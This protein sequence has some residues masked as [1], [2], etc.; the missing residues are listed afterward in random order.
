MKTVTQLAVAML[1]SSLFVNG[2]FA[3]SHAAVAKSVHAASISAAMNRTG[4][5]D[6]DRERDRRSKPQDVLGLLNLGPGHTVIDVFA[7]GGYY[8]QLM[9]Y[10]VGPDGKVLLHNNKA[11]KAYAGKSLSERFKDNKLQQIE[12]YDRE[13]GDLGL[14]SESIDAAIMIMSYH[15]LYYVDEKEGW[16]AIDSKKFLAQL[17]TALKPG[18][19]L[20][21][22]DHAAKAA[23][24]NSA[25]QDL[26]RIEEGFAKQ[27]IE[28]N[29]FTLIGSSKALRNAADD[30]STLVFDEAI[31]GKTDRF[32]L[33]FE[34]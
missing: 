29:G 3:D 18:G 14:A 25:A 13:V 33:L 6:A 27:D 16:P 30:R 21:I 15:D 23:S 24:G 12:I 9:A 32:V 20:L 10:L 4:R 26:H 22:V 7:A 2:A 5:S 17:H 28:S 34:K 1:A 11:Y 8:S 31:K 19:K